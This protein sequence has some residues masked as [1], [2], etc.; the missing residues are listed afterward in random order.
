MCT[1]DCGRSKLFSV[2][3]PVARTR[4][5]DLDPSPAVQPGRPSR[6]ARGSTTSPVCRPPSSARSHPRIR[7]A[8]KRSA[9]LHDDG[10]AR[11]GAP[12]VGWCWAV[13][14]HTWL[15]FA[16]AAGRRAV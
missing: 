8:G 5:R 6:R 14:R 15:G 3:G 16:S 1:L 12:E 9:L 13:N 10:R 2:G 11:R 4:S 7:L